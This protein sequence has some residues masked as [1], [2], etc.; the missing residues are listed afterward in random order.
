MNFIDL[1]P[2]SRG[3][4][5]EGAAGWLRAVDGEGRLRHLV[6]SE[7]T[8]SRQEAQFLGST[9]CRET[10]SGYRESTIGSNGREGDESQLL[11]LLGEVSETFGVES[12]VALVLGGQV[13]GYDPVAAYVKGIVFSADSFIG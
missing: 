13:R 7:L 3:C 9:A 5:R 11:P 2:R 1:S 8:P 10:P 6:P 12:V 4:L